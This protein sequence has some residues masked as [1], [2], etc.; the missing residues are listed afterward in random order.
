MTTDTAVDLKQNDRVPMLVEQLCDLTKR[1]TPHEDVR[2][3]EQSECIV[4]GRAIYAT[5]GH[6]AMVDACREA[7]A[8][9][10]AASVV[11]AFWHGIG[12]WQW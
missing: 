11:A 2:K 7:H 5:G 9:N 12:D 8:R 3:S 6:Q 4:I 10:S 1:W